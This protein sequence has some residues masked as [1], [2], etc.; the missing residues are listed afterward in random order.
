MGLHA[1]LIYF[2]CDQ[3][4]EGGVREATLVALEGVMAH[5]GKS[6]SAPVNARL[7][8]SLQGLLSSEEDVVRT[9]AAKTLGIVSQVSYLLIHL[10]SF[11]SPVLAQS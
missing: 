5:A 10:S 4:A 11:L 2:Q 9:S 3:A 1:L 6:V 8:T 7:L